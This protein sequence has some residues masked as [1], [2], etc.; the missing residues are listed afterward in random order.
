MSLHRPH[1]IGA[2][3]QQGAVLLVGLILLAILMIGATSLMNATISDERM[4]GN[5]KTHTEAFFAAEAGRRAFVDHVTA[6]NMDDS[7]PDKK[8][9]KIAKAQQ[10]WDKVYGQVT[11]NWGPNEKP[12][13]LPNF[14]GI[15]FANN[16]NGPASTYTVMAEPIFEGGSATPTPGK[17]KL[18]SLGQTGNAQ[19]MIGFDLDV[20]GGGIGMPPAPAAISCFGGACNVQAGAANDAPISGQNH[21]VPNEGCTGSA[22]WVDPVDADKAVVPA[23]FF[24]DYSDSDV[25]L[26]GGSNGKKKKA[27]TGLDRF[28]SSDENN[29]DVASGKDKSSGAVWGPNDYPDDTDGNNTAPKDTDYVGKD[30]K[31]MKDIFKAAANADS[32]LGTINNPKASVINPATDNFNMPGSTAGGLLI[33]EGTDENGNPGTLSNQGTGAYAGLIVIRDCNEVNFGGNFSVYGA[34]IVDAT[35]CPEGYT[36]FAGNGTPDVK[37]SSDALDNTG[38]SIGVGLNGDM[39]DWYEIIN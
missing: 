9:E 39:K 34:I 12:R 32:S 5:S 8:A 6:A 25:T 24:S 19:R 7:T 15:P 21:P 31:F 38:D 23:V 1:S 3:K 30:G 4:T 26:Q 18:I 35:G 29:T 28:N 2:H 27:F 36:P 13:N 37:Y 16:G 10:N 17:L 11:K 14:A 33:I 20:G 22:C